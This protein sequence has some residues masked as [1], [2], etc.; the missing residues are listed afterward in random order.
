MAET[1]KLLLAD[2]NRIAF[3]R[4][5]DYRGV[6]Y[7]PGDGPVVGSEEARQIIACGLGELTSLEW[8]SGM[9]MTGQSVGFRRK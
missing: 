6:H 9:K 2:R 5:C 1:N 7:L 4:S 8:E 3:F